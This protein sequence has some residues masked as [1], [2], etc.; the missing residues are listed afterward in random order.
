MAGRSGPVRVLGGDG[1]ALAE[2]LAKISQSVVA[3]T[4]R[5]VTL[6]AHEMVAD[7][8]SGQTGEI[9]AHSGLSRK[10]NPQAV[11]ADLVDTGAYRAAWK[12]AF[13]APLTGV[14]FNNSIYAAVLEYGLDDGSRVA[15][16]PARKTAKKS[17]KLF[18][19]IAQR[20]LREILR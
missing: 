1:L 5:E 15:F 19:A 9:P 11:V 16:Y 8:V 14:L 7:I 6:G 18:K 17:A 10:R 2:K 4:I 13:P 3:E 20:R 12:T